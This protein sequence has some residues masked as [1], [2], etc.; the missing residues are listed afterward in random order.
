MNRL[1][2]NTPDH[3]VRFAKFQT[4]RK[5]DQSPA[6]SSGF[7]LVELLVSTALVVLIMTLFAQI[8]GS[9]IQTI[10]LQRGIGNNDH[11]ARTLNTLMLSDLRGM[12][13]RQGELQTGMARGIVPLAP[14][15]EDGSRMDA[16]RQQGYFYYS[17]NDPSNDTDDVL[18]FTSRLGTTSTAGSIGTDSGRVFTGK[19]VSLKAPSE[20]SA[21]PTDI[22]NESQPEYDDGDNY[23]L[24]GQSRAAEISYF[25]RGGNLYR[26]VLLLRDPPYSDPS[27]PDQPEIVNRNG[28]NPPFVQSVFGETASSSRF[29]QDYPGT[30]FWSDFDYSATRKFLPTGSPTYSQVWFNSFNSLSNDPGYTLG[31]LGI[32]AY[33][34]GHFTIDDPANPHY[35]M[36]RE[37]AD[38]TGYLHS[39][40][41]SSPGGNF[42]GRYTAEETSHD[43][44][45]YPGTPIPRMNRGIPLNLDSNYIVDN[46]QNGER[47]AE[48]LVLTN[49]EAFDVQYLD[50]SEYARGLI[51]AQVDP[52]HGDNPVDLDDPKYQPYFTNLSSSSTSTGTIPF[53]RWNANLTPAYGPIDFA[54]TAPNQLNNVFDTWHPEAFPSTP[55]PPRRPVLYNSVEWEADTVYGTDAVVRPP[56]ANDSYVFIRSPLGVDTTGT[57]EPA[58]IHKPGEPT[59]DNGVVWICVDNRIGLKAIQIIIRYRDPG[60]DLPKQITL[61]HSFVE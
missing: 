13:Y 7:T 31:S 2:S 56:G 6:A 59:L 50:D 15:D 45:R 11:K 52:S 24:Q 8:Y 18:Q 38:S 16:G 28:P 9:T 17:E 34:F 39:N 29:G 30:N 51:L 25:L 3:H 41:V 55:S 44:F 35:G 49:V 12:T 61:V 57:S 10:T 36:P 1:H 20:A 40:P 32:P 58:W 47:I 33:R 5:T 4:L 42:I 26:R 53:R 19:A 43:T 37:F 14:G 21:F 60:K 54:T 23:N 46:L 22:V 27:K 48:D